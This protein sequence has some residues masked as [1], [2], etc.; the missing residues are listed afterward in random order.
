MQYYLRWGSRMFFERSFYIFRH[1]FDHVCSSFVSAND[2][3]YF[4]LLTPLSLFLLVV[5]PWLTC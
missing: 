2:G 4:A 5:A 3:I 1:S